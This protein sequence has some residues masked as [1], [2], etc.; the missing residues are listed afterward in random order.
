MLGSIVSPGAVRCDLFSLGCFFLVDCFRH[1]ESISVAGV[2]QEAGYADSR[3]CTRSQVE[4]D[5]S[6]IPYTSHLLDC[7]LCSRN[8]RSIVLLLQMMVQ[9]D[10][11][12][13]VDLY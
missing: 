13:V 5:Y 1:I 6:N 3:A 12:G 11:W 7:V 2:L 9:Q 10:R 8:V 4:V